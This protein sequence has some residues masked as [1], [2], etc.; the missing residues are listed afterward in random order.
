MSTS[1]PHSD[2]DTA[3][4]LSPPTAL[5]DEDALHR[6]FLAEY[7]ML[8][9]EARAELGAEAAALTP[10][11]VEGAFVRAW[12]A[13]AKLETPAQL[14]QFLVDDVHHA[15]ARALSR[16][17]A[18]H[19]FA[20]NDPHAAKLAAHPTSEISM[21]QSWA[22]VQHALH[23]EPH[24]PKALAD[25]AAHSR[26][27][28]AEHIAVI[29]KERPMWIMVAVAAAIILVMFGAVTWMNHL[30]RDA[31]I[32]TAVNA[33]DARVVTSLPGQ[34]G[35]VTL[36]DGSKVRLAPESKLAIPAG[37]GPELRAVKLDG[38]ATFTVAPGQK[39][40]FQVHGR[41][42]VVVAKGTQFTMRNYP[43]D[44]AVTVVVE[45]GAVD[46][47]QGGQTQLLAA[48]K[49]LVVASG[50]PVRDATAAERDEAAAWSTGTLAVSNRPLREVLPQLRRWYG[51]TVN[52]PQA[53]LLDRPVTVH[54]SLDS[55]R[56]AIRGI[57]ESTGLEFGYIGPNMV[58]RERA[59]KAST[60][61]PAKAPKPTKKR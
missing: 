6:A 44:G 15:A 11:V 56:Q 3:V 54:A 21:E 26:H 14:H 28:A 36:D 18:A 16:R 47:R 19:R 60:A 45:E 48:G 51:L 41:D 46:V 8:A 2:G 37:F 22:H 42:A 50:K 55:S 61:K 30:G 38:A 33:T 9:A 17:A 4:P 12:D 43:D 24:S 13:R 39:R 29:E 40:E 32:A 57:E 53:T 34:V 49:G 25:A 5:V 31:K 35:V 10:K 58:F 59:A 23:G 7:P 27:E 52:V 1:V 20:G